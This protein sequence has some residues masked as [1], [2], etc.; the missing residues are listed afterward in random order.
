MNKLFFDEEVLD[1]EFDFG[2]YME[3]KEVRFY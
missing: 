3:S 2:I 1:V